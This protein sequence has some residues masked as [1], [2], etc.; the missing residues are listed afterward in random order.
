MRSIRYPDE[1]SNLAAFD[2]TFELRNAVYDIIGFVSPSGPGDAMTLLL[3]YAFM[4]FETAA[5]ERSLPCG[6]QM[7]VNSCR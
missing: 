2:V 3:F 5:T 4:A 6:E 7:T 1:I